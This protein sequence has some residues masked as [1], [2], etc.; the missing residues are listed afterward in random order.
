M[1]DRGISL[2]AGEQTAKSNNSHMRY[3]KGTRSGKRL[4]ELLA[5]KV[6]ARSED[7]TMNLL[8]VTG[9]VGYGCPCFMFL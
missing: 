1:P 6:C 8:A 7:L 2:N 4:C 3:C 5:P 9:K